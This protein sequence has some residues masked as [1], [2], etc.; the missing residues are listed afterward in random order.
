MPGPAFLSLSRHP[1]SVVLRL[2]LWPTM[3]LGLSDLASRSEDD[4]LAGGLMAFAMI[5]AVSFLL[6]FADGLV[7]RTR[8]L[9]LV[10]S[11]TT[12]VVVG[13]LCTP[14]LI[15]VLRHAPHAT[16]WD[17]AVRVTLEDLPLSAAFFL[18][19][20]SVPVALGAVSGAVLRLAATSRG[21]RVGHT[22]E[23]APR[24]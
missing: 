16:T 6:S 22:A 3:I 13:P 2:L 14:R 4:A 10:W 12:V 1:V 20:V 23:L 19:L 7:L 11:V 5:V 8:A 15:E 17:Y 18:V 24:A 9:L 21:G